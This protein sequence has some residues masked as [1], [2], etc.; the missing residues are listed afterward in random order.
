[1]RNNF[2]NRMQM[3]LPAVCKSLSLTHTH[4]HTTPDVSSVMP[5]LRAHI[6][7]PY[8]LYQHTLHISHT[9]QKR[10][11]KPTQ[12]QSQHKHME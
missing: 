7:Q 1:M 3:L 9:L 6:P 12:L 10:S 8:F 5:C 11:I 4:T 2:S